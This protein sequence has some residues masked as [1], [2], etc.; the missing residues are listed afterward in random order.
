MPGLNIGI[1]KHVAIIMDGNGRWANQRGQSRAI[2]HRA[3]LKVVRKI[4]RAASE[5]GILALTLYAFSSENWNRPETE[6]SALMALFIYALNREVKRLHQNNIKL[7]I[8]GD[9]SRFNQQL[10]K[11]IY[12]AQSLTEN[13]TGL[14]LNI[15]A[16]YGGHWDILQATKKLIAQI[17]DNQL[18]LAQLDEAV[19]QKQ[20]CLADLPDVDLVI[21]TGGECRI[22]NFLVWQIAYAELYFIETLWPDFDESAFMQ[23]I[24]VFQSRE[25]R[26][27]NIK[28][29]S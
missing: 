19:F 17:E 10:Q 18:S 16:N 13:N 6:V 26:F 8:I 23:A 28:E 2:G 9:I 1:P 15:A 24:E 21:R 11:M 20:L 22:S 29:Q 7:R 25:R 3:G 4:V 27:G 12:Q 14:V 5:K